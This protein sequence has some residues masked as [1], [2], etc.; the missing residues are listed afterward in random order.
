MSYYEYD[1]SS[2]LSIEEYSKKLIG[3]SF[4]DVIREDEKNNGFTLHE[5]NEVKS[6][7]ELKKEA[8]LNKG[9]LGQLIEEHFFHYH[10][11]SDARP[12]FP[13]AGVELKVTPYKIVSGGRLTAKERL[14]ITMIDYFAV[15]NETFENSHLWNKAKLILLIYYLYEADVPYR[16]DYKIHFSKLFTPPEEDI[17]IIK[18]DYNI[19]VGKIKAGRAE[20]LSEGD[21]LYLGASTKSS[22]SS[23]RREQPYS[24]VPA[25]PR[26]FS[27]KVTYMTYV[28]N[29]YII[30][31]KTTYEPII[32]RGEV[33]TSFEDYVVN[34]I[35]NYIG[36]SVEEL[37]KEFNISNTKMPKNIEAILAYRILGIKG[38]QAEEFVKAGIVVKT[39]RISNNNKI[40]ES[41]SFP[42]FKFKQL[43]SEDWEDSIFGN[44]LRDTRFLF[45]V[46]KY[47]EDGVLRLKGCQFWNIPYEDLEVHV[48]DVWNRTKNVIL[49][50]IQKRYKSG[51]EENYLPLPKASENP[52]CHVRPHGRNAADTDE[53][54]NGQRYTKQCFW[55]NNSYIYQ[56][57]NDKIRA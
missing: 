31:G 46:Y 42:T 14:I 54:P 43:A 36:F 19:I 26:A 41:M 28:L 33:E 25:K 10:C 7:S 4:R 16:L 53:L 5:K 45:V 6:L 17:I 9:N 30:P 34:K 50:G 13:D 40:K 27:F 21:T 2:P 18:H 15:V 37:C 29:T 55:L 12:D 35:D 44:Y 1:S 51:M 39:I 8:K 32:K 22:D 38:N 20:E 56:Q 23:V 3:K 11:N 57:L 47:G 48:K 24:S 52:V 49:Q